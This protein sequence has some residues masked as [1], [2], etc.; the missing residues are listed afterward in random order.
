MTSSDN[1]QDTVTADVKLSVAGQSLNLRLT[2]PTGQTKPTRLLPVLRS[3]SESLV[4]AVE[5][6]ARAEGLQVSCKKG[7]GA[8]CRQLV[9][10]SET[11]A[12]RL[13][14]L[15]AEMPE[16]R[17]RVVLKRFEDAKQRIGT[18]GLL[19]RLQS[20]EQIVGDEFRKFGLDYFH[21]G[22]ACPF[23]EEESCSIHQERPL[24]CR[25]YLVVSPP[26]NCAR[27]TN[28]PVQVR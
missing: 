19:E 17:R 10:V 5:T 9:P 20:P 27:Q 23:L 21:Q 14:E 12:R 4:N 8:C 13:R 16:G 22:V 7:C 15:V 6:R 28:E 11:D 3:I 25:E 18:A 26:E 2:V 1:Q 24:V